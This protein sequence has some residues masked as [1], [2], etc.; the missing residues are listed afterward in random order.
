[1]NILAT[2]QENEDIDISVFDNSKVITNQN[3][4]KMRF[5]FRN[6]KRYQIFD[7]VYVYQKA[8]G[9]HNRKLQVHHINGNKHDNR[10]ENLQLVTRTHHRRL[11]TDNWKLINDVWYKECKECNN[12]LEYNKS[13]FSNKQQTICKKCTSSH[14]Q[15]HIDNIHKSQTINIDG[16]DNK[17]CNK[18][19]TLKPLNSKNFSIDAKNWSGFCNTCKVCK[20]YYKKV[21]RIHDIKENDSVNR[22]CNKCKE[23]KPLTNQYFHKDYTNHEGLT[24]ICKT[25]V[26]IHKKLMKL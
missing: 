5:Y 4:Y 9:K 18:C 1:M 14:Y 11:H 20:S 7:H 8:N 6:N 25:C 26:S 10:L 21:K 19:E 16:V 13:N 17:K 15:N 3:G 24:T 23:S 12:V 2:S 22:Q